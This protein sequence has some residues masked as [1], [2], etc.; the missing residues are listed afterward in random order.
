MSQTAFTLYNEPGDRY[1]RVQDVEVGAHHHDPK[2]TELAAALYAVASSG[3]QKVE[4]LK[5][6]ANASWRGF[7]DHEAVAATGMPMSSINS[8]RNSLV[9]SGWVTDSG[10]RRPSPVSRLDV[11]VWTVTPAG[12][13]QVVR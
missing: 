5:A 6:F 3:S 11:I 2:D 10:R 12:S 9:K 13:R 7:T 4:L 1:R 8:R